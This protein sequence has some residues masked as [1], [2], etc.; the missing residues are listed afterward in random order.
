MENF[1]STVYQAILRLIP[2][3]TLKAIVL[4]S[5]GFTKDSVRQAQRTVVLTAKGNFSYTTI[6]FSKRL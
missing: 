5:P 1:Y 4:A 2:Y 3:Q 6:S